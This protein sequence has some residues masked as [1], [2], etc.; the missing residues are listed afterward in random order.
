VH[1]D[2]S[3]KPTRQASFDGPA[4][5]FPANYSWRMARLLMGRWC[6]LNSTGAKWFRLLPKSC[7]RWSLVRAQVGKPSTHGVPE[8]RQLRQGIV[9]AEAMARRRCALSRQDYAPAWLCALRVLRVSP[10]RVCPL[11]VRRFDDVEA[12]QRIHR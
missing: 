7:P 1:R 9:F 5:A 10:I 2:S 6:C 4:L 11:R 8:L 12:D 3:A